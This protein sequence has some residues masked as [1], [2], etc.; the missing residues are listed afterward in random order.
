MYTMNSDMLRNYI[1]TIGSQIGGSGP[2]SG[3]GYGYVSRAIMPLA[4][5]AMAAAFG[6]GCKGDAPK[7]VQPS[8]N[9]PPVISTPATNAPAAPI[10]SVPTNV[11]SMVPGSKYRVLFV[12][13]S[14]EFSGSNITAFAQG[15]TPPLS[16][17][18]RLY[19]EPMDKSSNATPVV[20]VN[21]QFPW[22]SYVAGTRVNW[23]EKR[24][25][26]KAAAETN[27]VM[28]LEFDD[29]PMSP[30]TNELRTAEQV[31]TGPNA[32]LQH[33]GSKAT[34]T[35]GPNGLKVLNVGKDSVE[36]DR[37]I[38][39]GWRKAGT[40]YTDAGYASVPVGSGIRYP[41]TGFELDTGVNPFT[42]E[43]QLGP[44]GRLQF[45][46]DSNQLFQVNVS[47]PATYRESDARKVFDGVT[48]GS[49]FATFLKNFELYQNGQ[50]GTPIEKVRIGKTWTTP[51]K[52]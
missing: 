41:I 2:S 40:N 36:L 6:A 23:T 26:K 18:M 16:G 29:V 21:G 32:V 47:L 22:E 15:K 43:P 39:S 28:V 9:N 1:K 5:T 42:G 49:H 8:T 34:V 38:P 20:S 44:Y 33:F 14:Y 7:P 30:C 50:M 37:V 12:A 52:K 4:L 24:G 13:P 27:D 19:V 31:F 45:L 51:T 48:D 10:P 11:V 25:G 35:Y 17:S 3:S 46:G